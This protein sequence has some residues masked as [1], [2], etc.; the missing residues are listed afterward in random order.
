MVFFLNNLKMRRLLTYFGNRLDAFIVFEYEIISTV[1]VIFNKTKY[2]GG[3]I[4]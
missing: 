3:Y 2:L 4:F 1:M